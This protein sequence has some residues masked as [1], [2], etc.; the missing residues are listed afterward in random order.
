MECGVENLVKTG[1]S[2]FLCALLSIWMSL[3]K[4]TLDVKS[5]EGLEGSHAGPRGLAKAKL[6]RGFPETISYDFVT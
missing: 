2:G 5:A 1:K 6:K 4:K 3:I